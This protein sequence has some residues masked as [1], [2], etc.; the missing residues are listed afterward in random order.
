MS[1]PL[2]AMDLGHRLDAVRAR[3]EGIDALLVTRL[4]NV[5]YLTGFTGSAAMLL[6]TPERATFV[7]DGRYRDQAHDQLDAAGV[8]A[9][10]VIG[11]TQGEQRGQ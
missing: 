5:R 4:V 10:I 2:S 3:F 1:E 11:L 8:R 9:D 6:V 7:T